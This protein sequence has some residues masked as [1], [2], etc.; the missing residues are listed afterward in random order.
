MSFDFCCDIQIVGSEFGV[1]NRKLR[2]FWR[3]KGVQPGTIKVYLI[4]WPVSVCMYIYIY[5]YMCIYHQSQKTFLYNLI[6]KLWQILGC[7]TMHSLVSKHQNVQINPKPYRK[8]M[9]WWVIWSLIL[10]AEFCTTWDLFRVFFKS[11][12]YFTMHLLCIFFFIFSSLL[13]FLQMAYRENMT[14]NVM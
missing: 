4:K 9:Q 1:K 5:I 6:I 3:Q 12:F 11:Q 10:A 8:P 13:F 7:Q 2:Q 14:Q